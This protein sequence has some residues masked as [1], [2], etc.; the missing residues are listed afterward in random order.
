MDATLE[1][2]TPPPAGIALLV[3]GREAL[4]ERL[5]PGAWLRLKLVNAITLTPTP[6]RTRT[7]TL[8]RT[9][10]LTLILTR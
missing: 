3:N 4:S 8:T 2:P 7:L 6:T 9:P 1:A 10:T 5:R